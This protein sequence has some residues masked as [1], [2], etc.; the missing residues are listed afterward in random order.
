MPVATLRGPAEVEHLPYRSLRLN[1]WDQA[2]DPGGWTKLAD[3]AMQDFGLLP[4]QLPYWGGCTLTP[5]CRTNLS[6]HSRVHCPEAC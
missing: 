2:E 6:H 4:L 3:S 1:P 5:N